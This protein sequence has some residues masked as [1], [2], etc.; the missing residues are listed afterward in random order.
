MTRGLCVI[1]ILTVS[2]SISVFFPSLS[3]KG[4]EL[5]GAV[6]TLNVKFLPSDPNHFIAGTNMV[7]SALVRSMPP[8]SWSCLADVLVKGQRTLRFRYRVV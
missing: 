2:L 6:Q 4:D 8:L 1:V 7:G 5:W 3:H